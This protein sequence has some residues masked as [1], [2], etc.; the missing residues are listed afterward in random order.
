M[1]KLKV[2]ANCISTLPT[3][4]GQYQK[5]YSQICCSIMAKPQQLLFFFFFKLAGDLSE[6]TLSSHDVLDQPAGHVP[7]KQQ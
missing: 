1:P 7:E 4:A 2:K 3:N 5:K 6:S